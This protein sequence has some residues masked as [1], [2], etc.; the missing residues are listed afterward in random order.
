VKKEADFL[1]KS[2]AKNFC[3][4]GPGAV[5]ATTPQAQSAKVF[6]LLFLQKKKCLFL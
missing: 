3:Y 6:L 1:K 2:G 4:A 5:E